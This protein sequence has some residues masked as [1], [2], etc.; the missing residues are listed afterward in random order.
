MGYVVVVN[1][2]GIFSLFWNIVKLWLDPVTKSK[3]VVCKNGFDALHELIDPSQLPARYGGTSTE[4]GLEEALADPD[5]AA[6][7]AEFQSDA[8]W[9]GRLTD[10]SLASGQKHRLELAVEPHETYE[11]FFKCDEPVGFQARFYPTGTPVTAPDTDANVLI[12]TN[13]S[14]CE[15]NKVPNQGAHT[16]DGAGTLVLLWDN[17]NWWG[18]KQLT[19][20]ADHARPR[21]HL[22]ADAAHAAAPA[23]ASAAAP[24]AAAVAVEGKAEAKTDGEADGEGESAAAESKPEDA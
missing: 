18:A 16:G 23:A 7:R 5:Y 20:G 9:V 24:A 17:D 14:R 6:M 19:F 8:A 22:T 15:A 21:P 12:V 10:I 11:W 13:W 3:I 1:P 4:P 2:P